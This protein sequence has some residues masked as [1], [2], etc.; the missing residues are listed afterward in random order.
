MMNASMEGRAGSYCASSAAGGVVGG[1][2][3]MW[4]GTYSWHRITLAALSARCATISFV[5]GMVMR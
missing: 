4:E 1:V 5:T 3:S 2:G